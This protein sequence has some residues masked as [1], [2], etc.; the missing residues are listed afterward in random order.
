MNV[1]ENVSTKLSD[2]KET[3]HNAASTAKGSV[4]NFFDEETSL[5]RKTFFVILL[6]TALVGIISGFLLFPNKKGIQIN[7]TGPDDD[8]DDED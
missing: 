4:C 5:P 8:F 2:A 7:I 3:C 1:M 6:I